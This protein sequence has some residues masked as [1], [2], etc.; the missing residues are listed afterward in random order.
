MRDE[1]I[2]N[3]R[4]AFLD[5]WNSSKDFSIR[6]SVDLFIGDFKITQQEEI[7][8]A[9][10]RLKN[11]K[12]VES[13]YRDVRIVDL[14]NPKSLYKFTRNHSVEVFLDNNRL[15]FE[16]VSN[17]SSIFSRAQYVDVEVCEGYIILTSK[18][19]Q[20][21]EEGLTD[22]QLI[23]FTLERNTEIDIVEFLVDDQWIFGRVV[24]PTANLQAEEFMYYAYILACETDQL[25]HIINDFRLGDRY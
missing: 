4:R 2:P 15:K 21:K 22:K 5:T 14:F 17:I 9:Y 13:S 20:W 8:E 25:E 10:E 18:A 3:Y 24:H 7:A 12:G 16:F 6:Y 1:A 23:E 19:A 11:G